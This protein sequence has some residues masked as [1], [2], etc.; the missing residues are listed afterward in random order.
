MTPLSRFGLLVVAL[1]AWDPM[2]LWSSV[3]GIAGFRPHHIPALPA[4]AFDSFPWDAQNKLQNAEIKWQG[5]LRG[6]ESLA[7]DSRGRG[8]YAGVADGRIVRYDGADLG[9][10]TFAYTSKNR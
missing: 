6:P 5:E 9:W 10:T 1:L 7:F 8:P 2:N 3:G 4:G